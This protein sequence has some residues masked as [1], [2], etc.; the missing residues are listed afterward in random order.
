ML[1]ANVDRSRPFVIA[2]GTNA[3]S[4]KNANVSRPRGRDHGGE[5]RCSAQGSLRRESPQR[6]ETDDEPGGERRDEHPAFER[7][8]G[9]DER[10][11]RR[12]PRRLDETAP[13]EPHRRGVD[14][15]DRA[16]AHHGRHHERSGDRHERKQRE[17]HPPPADALGDA[18]G[19]HRAD[20]AG[21]DPGGRQDR[22]HAWAFGHRERPPD[23]HVADRR[24]DAGTEPLDEPA[25]NEDRHAG[26]EPADR[27]ADGEQHQPDDVGRAGAA[28]VGLVAGEDDPDHRAEEERAGH[29]AVPGDAAEVRLDL[30]QDRGDGERLER[31]ERHDGD[32]PDLQRPPPGERRLSGLGCVDLARHGGNRTANQG[33]DARRRRA[34]DTGGA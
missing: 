12:H 20:Q 29:P 30:R 28:T 8:A 19:E 5:T 31:H 34:R 10:R 1:A 13:H 17:E 32:Q 16:E 2:Y 14:V 6:A 9:H 18:L 4:P 21:H 15:G 11:T 25:E 3:S 26:R 33:G 22:E 7:E 23:R 24:H 27:E